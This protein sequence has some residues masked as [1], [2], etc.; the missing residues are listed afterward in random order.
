MGVIDDDFIRKVPNLKHM[1]GRKYPLKQSEIEKFLG[2]VLETGNRILKIV[3][4]YRV[5]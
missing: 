1:K 4:E 5:K 3:E 2:I